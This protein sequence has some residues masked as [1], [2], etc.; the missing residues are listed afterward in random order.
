MTNEI[1][2]YTQLS[3][4]VLFVCTLFFLYRVLVSQKDATIQLLKEKNSFI[5]RQLVEA[6]KFSPDA[7]AKSL[8]DRVRLLNE[9]IV[10][11]AKDKENNQE[12]INNKEKELDEIRK[13]G[14]EL[15]RKISKAHELMQEFFCPT[16]GEAMAERGYESESVDYQGQELDVEHEYVL[17]KCGLMV[18]DGE[19]IREC[20]GLG[21]RP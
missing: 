17:Y 5:E 3:S 10:R 18:V 1:I 8:S 7:L 12:K 15:S 4:I 11:L 20:A 21:A 19:E 6:S 9:E 14:E 2:F 16:C 13:E